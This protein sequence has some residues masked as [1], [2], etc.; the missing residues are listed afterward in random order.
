MLSVTDVL[1][2]DDDPGFREQAR[3]LLRAAGLLVAGESAD[4][5][6]A[7]TAAATLRPTAALVDVG[8]PD[9]DGFEVARRLTAADC[10]PRVL[11]TSSDADP[12][13]ARVIAACGA[14]GFVAKIDLCASDLRA[15][16]VG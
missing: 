2:V 6:A 10:P 14:V 12:P 5:T 8:L 7:L 4:G 13:P 15:Y 1:I 11:L 16:L 9:I 3:E